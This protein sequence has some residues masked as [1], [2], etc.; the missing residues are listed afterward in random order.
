MTSDPV[1]WVCD[2]AVTVCLNLADD[3]GPF[4]GRRVTKSNWRD[5]SN[6]RELLRVARDGRIF[7]INNR[8][9]ILSGFDLR[10]FANRLSQ[11]RGH[12]SVRPPNSSMSLREPL[13]DGHA[14]SSCSHLRPGLE[15][16]TS[17]PRERAC[18]MFSCSRNQRGSASLRHKC[19][20]LKERS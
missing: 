2:C 6:F 17:L 4:A 9:P 5:L 11:L 10:A 8:F 13:R 7:E 19:I 20:V 15:I 12:F 3:E 16:V 18:R 14:I 1:G